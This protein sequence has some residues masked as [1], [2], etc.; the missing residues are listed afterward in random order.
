MASTTHTDV[1]RI[2]F[3]GTRL[4]AVSHVQYTRFRHVFRAHCLGLWGYPA[5]AWSTQPKPG[6]FK[7]LTTF[8][9]L[10]ASAQNPVPTAGL[11][12]DNARTCKREATGIP[13]F[14]P[15]SAAPAALPHGGGHA[16]ASPSR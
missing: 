11:T 12:P 5:A 3:P 16:F 15:G 7:W 4:V 10:G 6:D 8:L 14:G 9:P 2:G 1:T 13:R